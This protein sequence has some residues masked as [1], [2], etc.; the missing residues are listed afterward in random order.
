[1]TQDTANHRAQIAGGAGHKQGRKP[2]LPNPFICSLYSRYCRKTGGI[3]FRDYMRVDRLTGFGLNIGKPFAD[4][5]NV[6]TSNFPNVGGNY[7]NG[8]NAGP[9]NANFNNSATETNTN[10][11]SR[12]S[13]TSRSTS[14][15]R[16][17]EIYAASA[18]AEKR[19]LDENCQHYADAAL[20]LS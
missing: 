15:W 11:G 14:G 17:G 16:L 18:L 7:N 3:V 12:L 13:C 20:V 10:I 2:R 19:Q 8:D 9:F 6:N 5:G 4:N 1:M